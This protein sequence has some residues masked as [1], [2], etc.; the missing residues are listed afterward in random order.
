MKN[1]KSKTV[2]KILKNKVWVLNWPHFT[3]YCKAMVIE[4]VWYQYKKNASQGS[5]TETQETYP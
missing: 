1:K 3:I 5:R 4:A 2:M